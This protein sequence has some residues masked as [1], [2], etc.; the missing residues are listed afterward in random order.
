MCF[1]EFREK[2]MG[3]VQEMLGD[4]YRIGTQDYDGLNGTAGRAII[5]AREG[6][7][8]AMRINMDG[9]Y[10]EYRLGGEGMDAVANQIAKCCQENAPD[11][12]IRIPMLER[13]DSVKGHIFAKLVNTEKNRGILAGIPNKGYLDLSVTYYARIPGGVFGGHATTIICNTHMEC[14]G[15]GVEEIHRAAC[16]NMQG[17]GEATFDSLHDLI[18]P[19]LG[20]ET[21]KGMGKAPI[22]VLSNRHKENGAAQILNQDI[23]GRVSK[24]LK[25][26]IWVLPSSIHEAILIPADA[27]YGDAQ[28]LAGI[29]RE[30]N[31][32]QVRAE[33]ALSDHVYLYSR[34]TGEVSIGA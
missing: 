1:K 18:S 8:A 6:T 4:G 9:Y 12:D 31:G 28:R 19:C 32:T 29:V 25:S 33:E 3:M 30:I 16:G 21:V 7:N 5:V 17:D 24:F 22:F 20:V 15:V 13:W 2:V 14:W 27:Q 23:M 26:D 10:K 34:L 11:K